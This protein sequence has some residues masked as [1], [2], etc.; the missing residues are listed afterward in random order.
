[1]IS[2]ARVTARLLRGIG[3]KDAELAVGGTDISS[4]VAARPGRHSNEYNFRIEVV[5]D[6]SDTDTPSAVGDKTLATQLHLQYGNPVC[7]F[8]CL[9]NCHWVTIRLMTT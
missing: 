9:L 5:A 7:L 6:T 3:G 8:T 2:E 4:A 1:M